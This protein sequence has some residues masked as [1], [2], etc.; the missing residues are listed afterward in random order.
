MVYI[1]KKEV[2]NLH[3]CYLDCNNNYYCSQSDIPEI[4]MPSVCVLPNGVIALVFQTPDVLEKTHI[5]FTLDFEYFTKIEVKEFNDFI[6]EDEEIYI[7]SD[8]EKK[9]KLK[10]EF[11]FNFSRANKSTI[12]VRIND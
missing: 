12:D 4:N 6:Y 1:C 9:N 2:G 5:Y 11:E 8:S 10:L 3:F 7:S